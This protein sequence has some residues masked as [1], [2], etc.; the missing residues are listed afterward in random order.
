M[1]LSKR[2]FSFGDLIIFIKFILNLIKLK[3][4]AKWR[5]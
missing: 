3:D 1:K 5:K 2:I 4:Y